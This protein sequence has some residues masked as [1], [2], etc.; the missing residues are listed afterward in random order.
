MR[1]HT[2]GLTLE[3]RLFLFKVVEILS[4]DSFITDSSPQSFCETILSERDDDNTL[5][6]IQNGGND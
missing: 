5:R 4:A 1:K 2:E 3:K 6:G